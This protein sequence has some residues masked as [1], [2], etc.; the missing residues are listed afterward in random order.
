VPIDPS[1]AIGAQLP[2]EDFSWTSS[3]VLLYHLALGAGS[4]TG[5][6]TD[7]R[8]LG[9]TLHDSRLQVLPSFGIVAHLRARRG[10]MARRPRTLHQGVT[11]GAGAG[12]RLVVHHLTPAG[13]ALRQCGDRNPL[14]ADPAFAKA[15]GFPAPIL[16]GL[17]SY[18]IVLRTVVDAMLD[19][20]TARMG[21]LRP[22]RRGRVPRRDHPGP[23]VGR[24][25]DCRGERHRRFGRHRPRRRSGAR[26][27]RSHVRLT[28]PERLRPTR[29]KTRLS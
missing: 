9:Y 6:P 1:I 16:H 7:P 25:R 27:L 17:C 26:R 20:D 14:H 13:L 11:A 5:D 29:W 8:A 10:W 28:S 18:G 4:R 19:G 15:A 24:A 23:G 3:D 12:R 2:V 21:R 22:V